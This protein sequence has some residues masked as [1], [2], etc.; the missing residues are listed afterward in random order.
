MK[1]TGMNVLIPFPIVTFITAAPATLPLPTIYLILSHRI[2][3]ISLPF[4]NSQA[5]FSIDKIV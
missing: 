5:I 4:E 1:L 2:S 3:V